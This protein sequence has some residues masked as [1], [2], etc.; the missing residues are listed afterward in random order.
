MK[1]ALKG[2]VALVTGASR[3]LGAAIATELGRQGAHLVGT[4]TT[5]EGAHQLAARWQEQDLEG[6]SRVLDVRLSESV[7]ALGKWLRAERLSPAI[8]VNNA[9]ITRDGLL[10]LM[11]EE[12]WNEVIATDLTS[13]YRLSRLCLRFML[14]ERY[15]RII[16]ISSVVGETG[17]PGQCNYAAAKAGILGL[18]MS[19]AREVATRNITVNVVTPGFIHSAMSA[20]LDESQREKILAQIPLGRLGEA[21]EVAMAVA[22]LASP[23]AAYITGNVLRVNGGLHMG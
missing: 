16:N 5:M 11:S 6:H 21:E 20:A 10:A 8:L 19:L 12:S 23:Q 1:Q 7:Q 22:F 14:K 4:A 18:S 9:G 17:N 15:G 2:Q 3:G 13:V